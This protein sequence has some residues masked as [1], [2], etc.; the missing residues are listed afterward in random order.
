MT[1]IR[2]ARSFIDSDAL[3][4]VI[5]NEYD[6]GPVSCQLFSK[7]VR[8]QDNDHYLVR[9]ADNTRYVAR[10]YQLGTPLGREES[11]Y[12]YELDWL[13][14]LKANDVS[15]SYP[16]ARRDGRFLGSVD[17]PEGL[18]YYALFSFAPGQV[19]SLDNAEQL[20]QCGAA[21]AR[22]HVVSNQYKSPYQRQPMNLEYLVDKS[23][24]RIK[25]LWDKS[26]KDDLDLVIT[27]AQEAKEEML[28]LLHNEEET[29]DSWGP[30]GGDFHNA[31]VRFDKNGI[32]TFFNFDLCGPGWRAYDIAAFLLNTNLMHRSEEQ[33]EAFFA[34]YYSE[35]PL[36]RNEH[37][38]IS[39]LLT[40]R[41]VW[42]TSLFTVSTGMTGH[43]FIASI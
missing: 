39:P 13:N 5:T 30:I 23:V 37:A 42:L 43:T 35:R 40:I 7:M 19:M 2:V 4:E 34:G 14:F 29:P 12:L 25:R 9:T 31:S 32:P 33:S 11:D 8:T 10:I 21:I 27:S 38:A 6:L 18:R 1:Q 26:R 17:A 15:V 22:I 16:L 28:A 41:R 36:S 3:A 20:Y 24:E